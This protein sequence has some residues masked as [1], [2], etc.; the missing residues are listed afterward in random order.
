MK[1]YAYGI[2]EFENGNEGYDFITKMSE[3]GDAILMCYEKEKRT[4]VLYFLH[5][6]IRKILRLPNKIFIIAENKKGDKAILLFDKE[7]NGTSYEPF[8]DENGIYIIVDD[9]N[10]ESEE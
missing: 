8:E 5:D 6:L 1:L 9:V 10:E 7:A 3:I 2:I 4:E